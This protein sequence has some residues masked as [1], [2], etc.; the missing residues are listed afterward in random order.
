M[1]PEEALNT[2]PKSVALV[3]LGASHSDFLR[4]C[5]GDKGHPFP[6]DEV[7][8]VNRGIACF[9][10]DKAFIMDDLRWIEDR[11]RVYSQMIQQATSPVI[12]STVYPEY[13]MAVKY[14]IQ[15]VIRCI[16]DDYLINT[17]AYAVAYAIYTGV[18]ELSLYGC[19]FHYPN[20]AE[21]EEGGQN[22][23]YLLGISR[24][25]GM[26]FRLPPSTT[27]MAAHT[28]KM[29]NG[30]MARPLYG[31]HR[32]EE[33]KKKQEAGRPA[34][35]SSLIPVAAMRQFQAPPPGGVQ[36][37]PG[38]NPGGAAHIKTEEDNNG[39]GVERSP[40][41]QESGGDGSGKD[42]PKEPLREVRA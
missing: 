41:L 32:M 29:T 20:R 3:A 31:Y 5:L 33:R 1:R 6:F 10:H 28:A 24:M 30:R 38:V 4:E 19:D 26:N 39:S 27:L 25:F 21:A 9:K 15:E 23:T 36:P 34:Q 22:V 8:V 35:N 14:P 18:K 16:G 12:T 7:W 17:V 13:P 40:R 2:R 37:V 11:D 42:D